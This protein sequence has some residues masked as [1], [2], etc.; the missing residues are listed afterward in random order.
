MTKI[1][2]VVLYKNMDP[3]ASIEFQ[4]NITCPKKMS[5]LNP[6]NDNNNNSV[7]SVRYTFLQLRNCANLTPEFI[8]W[9][10]CTAGEFALQYLLMSNT[11]K[12]KPNK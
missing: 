9:T 5:L 10:G 1:I 6:C 2:I 4:T 12:K 8:L 11:L 7:G 3:F